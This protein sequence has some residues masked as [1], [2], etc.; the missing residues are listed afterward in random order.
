MT[1]QKENIF[2][3][4]YDAFLAGMWLYAY[5][6]D[7]EFIY[8]PR[9]EECHCI[10]DA[11]GRKQLHRDDGP[12]LIVGTTRLF[13]LHG[14]KVPE[15]LVMTP[16]ERLDPA[17]YAEIGNADAKAE[18]IR[19]IGVERMVGLG[20]V[21]DTWENYSEDWWTK[22]EYQLVDMSPIFTTLKYA[23]YLKMKN[24]TLGV[25]HLEPVAKECRT[26]KDAIRLTRWK[27]RDPDDYRTVN[28]K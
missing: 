18:F 11:N 16:A 27:G 10:D 28:I 2:E 21:V 19:K 1:K 5:V 3:P 22:S 26:V 7:D 8:L 23:P 20:R 4:I 14:V 15:W 17:R 25:Y 24:Q 13:Y 9:P 6:S 12:A